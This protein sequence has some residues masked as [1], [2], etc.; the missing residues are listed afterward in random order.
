MRLVGQRMA[1]GV[2]SCTVTMKLQLLL[3]PL[4]SVAMQITMVVPSA[5]VLPEAGV[6]TSTGLV[7][8]RSEVVTANVPMAPAGLLHSSMRFVEQAMAGAVVSTTETVKLHVLVLPLE[9]VARQRTV[10]RPGAKVL[11]EA[12]VQRRVAL[13]SQ[14]SEDVTTKVATE[15]FTLAHSSKILVEHE[16]VGGVVSTTKT[17]KLHV[18][19]LPLASDTE[20]LT[21]VTPGRNR[22]PEAGVQMTMMF[23]SHM[24]AV[25]AA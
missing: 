23:V 1:G 17:V 2:V 14:I 15:P 5:K 9:S 16:T 10:V 8:Q 4:E 3:L 13:V 19:L 6:Q 18:L 11:P 25:V 21:A 20:Q 22:L 12:G 7:S 24:S